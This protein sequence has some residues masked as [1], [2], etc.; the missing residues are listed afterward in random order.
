MEKTN[1]KAMK[2][3]EVIEELTKWKKDIGDAEVFIANVDE[4]CFD[5]LGKM[6]SIAVAS[7]GEKHLGIIRGNVVLKI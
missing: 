7:T 2:I 6:F 3:S 5:S 4:V 1:E